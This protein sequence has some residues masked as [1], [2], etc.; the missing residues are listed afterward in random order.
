MSERVE[1]LRAC[2]LREFAISRTDRRAD[3]AQHPVRGRPARRD[4]HSHISAPHLRV[5]R[6]VRGCLRGRRCTRADFRGCPAMPRTPPD[7]RPP[8]PPAATGQPAHPRTG[9]GGAVKANG[10]GPVGALRQRFASR[11]KAAARRRRA[12]PR[13]AGES[14]P[15]LAREH[16]GIP[17]AP[18][19]F[20]RPGDAVFDI[21][22]RTPAGPS[23]T[24]AAAGRYAG[25]GSWVRNRGQ[26]GRSQLPRAP[27]GTSPATMRFVGTPASTT[28]DGPCRRGVGGLPPWP[29]SA[30][31]TASR[32]RARLCEA[33]FPRACG[34]EASVGIGGADSGGRCAEGGGLAR[35]WGARARSTPVTH[36]GGRRPRWPQRERTASASPGVRPGCS[37]A[38]GSS[39]TAATL[40]GD[41]AR[42][43]PATPRAGAR[44]GCEAHWGSRP[45]TR[46]RRPAVGVG[47][48]ASPTRRGRQVTEDPP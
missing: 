31:A 47:R 34:W 38:A 20:E 23:G 26:L 40:P 45:P 3:T 5:V 8:D 15:H 18:G 1:R 30:A 25:H 13:P 10:R 14:P 12:D 4:R 48:F 42:P 44:R 9:P 35:M 39:P 46:A 21:D 24:A 43:R 6:A 22:T 32:T 19:A 17:G 37:I 7:C 33:R 27:A 29:L 28:G 2:E 36:E 41:A 16:A 11:E